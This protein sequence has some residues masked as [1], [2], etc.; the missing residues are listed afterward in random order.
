MPDIWK[1]RSIVFLKTPIL[2]MWLQR[3]NVLLCKFYNERSWYIIRNIGKTDLNKRLTIG[4]LGCTAG[5]GVTHLAITLSNLCHSKLHKKTALLELHKRK[6]LSTIPSE[7]TLPCRCGFMGDRTVFDIHGVDYYPDTISCSLILEVLMN[8][9]SMNFCAV[10]ENLSSEVS[11]H[12][13][14]GNIG[15]Y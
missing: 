14:S 1:I 4:I 15:N 7:T 9:V 10:T 3:R 11:H 2:F 6:N 12:G 8:A 13:I 5:A